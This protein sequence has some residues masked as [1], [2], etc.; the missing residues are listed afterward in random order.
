MN[1]VILG[2]GALGSV[3]GGLMARAD[4]S[5]TLLDLNQAHM[6]AVS[7]NGLTLTCD[8]ESFNL[9][10]PAMRPE[11]YKGPADLIILLTKTMH[12]GMALKSVR[13]L[14]DP[15]PGKAGAYVLT[16]QNG[17]G[18]SERVAELVSPDRILEGTTMINGR[19]LGPG[20]VATNGTSKTTF[21]AISEAARPFVRE[22]E[23][24]LSPIGFVHDPDANIVIW[25]K[26]AFNCAMNAIAAL[27]GARVGDI[28]NEPSAI[29][30][31]KAGAAEVVAI[32][33]AK[34]IATDLGAVYAQIDKALA[35]HKPH[36]PSMLQDLEAGRATEIESLCG[37]VERE[38]ENLSLAA[39][40][41][42]ALAALIRLRENAAKASWDG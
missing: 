31:A 24:L 29:V 41:N 3:L 9:K 1:I 8:G 38:A 27:G 33:N 30:L 28:A 25:Q 23:Q 11:A 20:S 6:D 35:E 13:H 5:V 16:I 15:G 18:N 32:A 22:L 12:S 4:I 42:M 36:K 10:L 26:A 17:L 2:A 39:P 19:F 40:I 34:G 21:R 14:I 7:T 37:T